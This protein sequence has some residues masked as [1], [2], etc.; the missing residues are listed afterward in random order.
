MLVHQT[1]VAHPLFCQ[2]KW[3]GDQFSDRYS[4]RGKG[5]KA[6]RCHEMSLDP[7]FRTDDI[8]AVVNMMIQRIDQVC[9]ILIQHPEQL[10]RACSCHF[11]SNSRIGSTEIFIV[12]SQDPAGKGICQSHA[13]MAAYR[14]LRP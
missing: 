8:V 4:Q 12:L 14:G 6:G 2:E 11:Q 9:F 5:K 1:A 7:F 10:L 13:H 3:K